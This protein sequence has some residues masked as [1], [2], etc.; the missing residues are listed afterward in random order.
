MTLHTLDVFT[1]LK[2]RCRL[3]IVRRFWNYEAVG[4]SR[5]AQEIYIF[6]TGTLLLL[7]SLAFKCGNPYKAGSIINGETES[8]PLPQIPSDFQRFLG[9]Y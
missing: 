1:V 5:K 3:S 6:K 7:E 8:F 2:H 9:L 4:F